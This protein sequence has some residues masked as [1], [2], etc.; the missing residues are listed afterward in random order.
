MDLGGHNM[1][2]QYILVYIHTYDNTYVYTYIRMVCV[3]TYMHAYTHTNTHITQAVMASTESRLLQQL[4]EELE[5]LDADGTVRVER[6]LS[7]IPKP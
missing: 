5:A 4:D 7:G 3:H 1:Y 2:V 6:D